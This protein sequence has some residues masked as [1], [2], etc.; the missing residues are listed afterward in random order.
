MVLASVWL[1]GKRIHFTVS[2]VVLQHNGIVEVNQRMNSRAVESLRP[3]AS[4]ACCGG[5]TTG[6]TVLHL[7]VAE[8]L[9]SQ[10]PRAVGCVPT[11]NFASRS[12]VQLTTGPM[13]FGNASMSRHNNRIWA[14]GVQPAGEAVKFDGASKIRFAASGVSATDL[15]FL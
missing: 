5:S 4:T 7:Q 6:G 2:N 14:I 9:P 3:H 1:N 12:A 11:R 10:L 13:S 15:D 8:L